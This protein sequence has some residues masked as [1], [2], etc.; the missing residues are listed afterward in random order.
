MSLDEAIHRLIQPP[1]FPVTRA[2]F[3]GDIIVKDFWNDDFAIGS[4][5]VRA[6]P[7]P[8][9]NATSGYRIEAGGASVVY[10]PDHQQPI[11]DPT[12]V[13]DSVLELCD[14]AD[15]LI[16]DGQYPPELF[17]QRAHWGHS[18]PGYAVEVARQSG[19]H[20]LALFS[21]DPMH[22]DADLEAIEANAQKLGRDAGLTEVFSAREG[23]RIEL[24]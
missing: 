19:V 4:A 13:P 1:Y 3:A 7:V 12:H 10:I 14:G 18:T 8:H 21:H 11:D 17:A 2:D 22:S 23:M 15:L 24:G 16:H 20:S 9:T 5:K 6:R